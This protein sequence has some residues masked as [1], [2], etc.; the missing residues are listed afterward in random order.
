MSSRCVV[1]RCSEKSRKK[2]QAR[3]QNS[4]KKASKHTFKALT[5][6]GLV[7]HRCARHCCGCCDCLCKLSCLPATL[8][9][10]EEG[11]VAERMVRGREGRARVRKREAKYYAEKSGEAQ[12][13]E[14]PGAGQRIWL[15]EKNKGADG[16]GGDSEIS[17]WLHRLGVVSYSTDKPVRAEARG[18]CIR[19]EAEKLA[20][21]FGFFQK[22]HF[23]RSTTSSTNCAFAPALCHV[24]TVR[25]RRDCA[26]NR[27][28]SNTSSSYNSVV[29][30]E[31]TPVVVTSD[32]V[33]ECASWKRVWGRHLQVMQL[34][35]QR[36]PVWYEQIRRPLPKSA[37]A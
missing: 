27:S 2:Q 20:F 23:L 12:K 15:A 10:M 9:A 34:I 14:P 5:V 36:L 4:L 6:G 18:R 31:G 37:L 25:R 13:E 3:L 7:V 24:F 22:L 8:M 17:V 32:N 11:M 21:S 29:E 28:V 1:S 16:R 33:N 30:T 35:A 26:V 19:E